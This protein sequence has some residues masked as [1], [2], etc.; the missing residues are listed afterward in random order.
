MQ[1]FS[2][3]HKYLSSQIFTPSRKSHLRVWLAKDLRS[4]KK[5]YYNIMHQVIGARWINIV[6][7]IDVDSFLLKKFIKFFIYFILFLFLIYIYI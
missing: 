6:Q 3:L 1:L 2:L 7:M 5:E 4:Y